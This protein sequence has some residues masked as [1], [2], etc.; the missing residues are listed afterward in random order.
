M[1]DNI[2]TLRI[3]WILELIYKMSAFDTYLLAKWSYLLLLHMETNNETN[4]IYYNKHK[5]L[6]IVVPSIS[7]FCVANRCR[8][9]HL[10]GSL[11]SLHFL[12]GWD[13]MICI[14]TCIFSSHNLSKFI[15]LHCDDDISHKI[16]KYSKHLD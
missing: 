14:T 10:L 5:F 9:R 11:D 3:C 1:G 4:H 8:C 12:Y 15:L 7:P 16:M 2:R 6:D 13:G